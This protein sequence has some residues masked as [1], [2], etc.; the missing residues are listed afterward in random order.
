MPAQEEA[1]LFDDAVVWESAGVDRDN[2][3]V[4][5][6][7]YKIMVRWDTN[8]SKG[9]DQ[10]GQLIRYDA[11]LQTQEEYP[12]GSIFWKGRLEEIDYTDLDL[13]RSVSKEETLDI[14]GIDTDRHYNLLRFN[15][16]L[17]DIVGTG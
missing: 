5:L 9:I 8:S 15:K 14:R 3:P 10:T 16:A 4:V 12:L 13:F 1:F 6:T 17:P 11:S 7:P 2:E